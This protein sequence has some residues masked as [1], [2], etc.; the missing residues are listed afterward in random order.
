[1]RSVH[2]VPV[3]ILILALSL[4]LPRTLFSYGFKIQGAFLILL[5]F[6]STTFA[7]FKGN[8]KRLNS[9][10]IALFLMLPVVY[11]AYGLFYG[12]DIYA[13]LKE[14]LFFS[15]P[16]WAFF[17]VV[18]GSREDDVRKLCN[19]IINLGTVMSIALLVYELYGLMNFTGR[20]NYRW[21]HI[22]LC[23]DF[24]NI[25]YILYLAVSKTRRALFSPKYILIT[26]SLVLTMGRA[27]LMLVVFFLLF[28]LFSRT[29]RSL[30]TP[31]LFL[32]TCIIA[33]MLYLAVLFIPEQTTSGRSATWRLEEWL[34][35]FRGLKEG[36]INPIVGNGFGF[37]L[38]PLHPLRLFSGKVLDKI[39]RYHSRI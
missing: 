1:M 6:I 31:S 30:K 18:N 36:V 39:Q 3:L 22:L 24:I 21:E 32:T 29:F 14:F 37:L 33:S 34:S 35:Y 38:T 9:T 12:N 23:V 4:P 8:I 28:F 13:A 2:L 20:Y 17:I 15:T 5:F 10:L 11:T 7:L 27:E 19:F 16:L 25:A 26:S